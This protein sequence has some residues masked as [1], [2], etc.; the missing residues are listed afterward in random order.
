M[1]VNWRERTR[2]SGA[3]PNPSRFKSFWNCGTLLRIFPIGPGMAPFADC[4]RIDVLN[5]ATEPN[6]LIFSI[7]VIR[8]TWMLR[9][10]TLSGTQNRRK[11]HTE[12]DNYRR[13]NNSHCHVA[14][15]NKLPLVYVLRRQIKHFDYNNYSKPGR[16]SSDQAEHEIHGVR[17]KQFG[18]QHVQFWLLISG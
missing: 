8:D 14:I 5:A 13:Q 6:A 16:K 7:K 11:N 10:E 17:N 15:L 1:L 9:F 4:P 18:R 12:G 2:T 3:F